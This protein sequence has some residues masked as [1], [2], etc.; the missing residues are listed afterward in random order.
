LSTA[1][2]DSAALGPFE[3]DV[4]TAGDAGY[5]DARKL[6]NAMIDRKPR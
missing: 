6:F 4:L 3:G 2:L 5:D 1:T